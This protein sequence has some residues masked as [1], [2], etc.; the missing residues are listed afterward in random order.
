EADRQLAFRRM[1]P[2]Q[3][4]G[5]RASAFL[6]GIPAL[7]QGRHL[8]KPVVGG[9]GVTGVH[10]H[11]GLLVTAATASISASWPHGNWNVR[12]NASLSEVGSKPTATTAASA[13]AAIF[14]ASGEIKSPNAITPRPMRL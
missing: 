8:V 6:A 11:D 4:F 7:Q 2:E 14:F 9:I 12:S 13:I 3:H 1:R 10:G 5:D